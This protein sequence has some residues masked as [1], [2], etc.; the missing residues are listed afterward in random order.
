MRKI[1]IGLLMAAFGLVAACDEVASTSG[2][3]GA[4]SAGK[5]AAE[6]KLEADAKSLNQVSKKIIVN[7]T[8]QGALVGAAAGCG[9]A[10]IL[11]G[12]GSDCAAGAA[13]GGLIGGIG[14]NQVGQKAAQKN[15]EIVQ[16]AAVVGNLAAVSKRLN[17]VE[18]ELRSVLRSQ[19][20]EIRSLRRQ[21]QAGQ[22]SQS[23]YNARVRAIKSNRA[24]VNNE[25]VK[26]E[27]S[28]QEASNQLASAQKQGQPGLTKARQAAASNQR[29]LERTRSLIKQ[30][31]A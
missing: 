9:I 19:D 6:R 3:P 31:D 12:N 17:T 22:V 24:V 23:A 29:R 20:A 25:L 1:L 7:N 8:V 13:A 27:R 18:A 11:G 30:I 10:L 15:K 14:G 26:S 28:V 2:V 16:T 21:V 4:S 5:T